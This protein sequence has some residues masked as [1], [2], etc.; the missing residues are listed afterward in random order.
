LYKKKKQKLHQK[1]NKKEKRWKCLK[2][3][4]KKNQP[5]PTVVEKKVANGSDSFS[6]LPI[7]SNSNATPVPARAKDSFNRWFSCSLRLQGSFPTA[8]PI[9]FVSQSGED[10]ENAY[11]LDDKNII[12][13]IGKLPEELKESKFPLILPF[14]KEGEVYLVTENSEGESIVFRGTLKRLTGKAKKP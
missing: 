13:P 1:K 11:R 7:K 8:V 3:E 14:G 2:K 12:V 4:K 9:F 5:G 6:I 10:I